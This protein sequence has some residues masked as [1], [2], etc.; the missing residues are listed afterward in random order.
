MYAASTKNGSQGNQAATRWQS[1]P[2]QTWYR[3]SEPRLLTAG[4]LTLLW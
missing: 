4:T 2:L 1:G 3:G